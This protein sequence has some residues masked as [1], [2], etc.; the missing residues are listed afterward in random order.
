M[1]IEGGLTKCQVEDPFGNIIGLRGIRKNI[2]FNETRIDS[3]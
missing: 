3:E 2:A 1:E